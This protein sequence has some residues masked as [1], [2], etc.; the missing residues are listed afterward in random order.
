[1]NECQNRLNKVIQYMNDTSGEIFFEN[2][3]DL[4]GAIQE[5]DNI[6]QQMKDYLER[7]DMP[8]QRSVERNHN[9]LKEF[10]GDLE[11]AEDTL[12]Q[13]ERVVYMDPQ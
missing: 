9:S 6:L 2:A 5:V 11:W 4:Y 10:E 3:G 7:G 1:M 12:L 13:I 8:L